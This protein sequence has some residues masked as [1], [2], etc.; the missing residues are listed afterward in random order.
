MGPQR[1]DEQMGALSHHKDKRI[2]ILYQRKRKD[3]NYFREI[4]LL[5]SHRREYSHAIPRKCHVQLHALQ[6]DDDRKYETVCN[7]V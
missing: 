3:P 7:H 1:N 4:D 2:H 6:P 5:L